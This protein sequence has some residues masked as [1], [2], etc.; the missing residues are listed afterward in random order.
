MELYLNSCHWVWA[1]SYDKGLFRRKIIMSIKLIKSVSMIPMGYFF[2]KNQSLINPELIPVINFNNSPCRWCLPLKFSI[3]SLPSLDHQA[4]FVKSWNQNV[5]WWVCMTD[6]V[7][8]V[9]HSHENTFCFLV[10][11]CIKNNLTCFL[12]HIKVLLCSINTLQW[13]AG[14]C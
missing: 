11:C 14:P 10:K 5:F 12:F 6:F 1:S 13:Q 2:S 3:S 7:K 9:M 4:D 8:S